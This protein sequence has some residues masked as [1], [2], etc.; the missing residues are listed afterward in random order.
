[1]DMRGDSSDAIRL[2]DKRGEGETTRWGILLV[3]FMRLIAGLWM[4]QG[5]SQ[6]QL[7]L[8]LDRP[9][10]DSVSIAVGV[11]VGFFA[12][13]DLVGAI[14]LWLA[15]PWGGVLWLLITFAQII[16]AIALPNFFEGGRLVVFL[17]IILVAL[18][19]FLTFKAAHE[20]DAG[21][22]R[23]MSS[24]KSAAKQRPFFARWRR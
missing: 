13:M 11:A 24:R 18:Y 21:Q 5:L 3:V 20:F 12:V 22:G 15:T 4:V 23:I 19:M 1:M 8:T 2:R 6:W 17:D 9:L 7:L 14:G 16:V 10:F